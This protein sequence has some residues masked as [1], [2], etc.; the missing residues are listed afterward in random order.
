MDRTR[1]ADVANADL[2][3]AVWRKSRRSNNGGEC[4]EVADL[5]TS[6]GVRDSKN[7]DAGHLTFAPDTWAAFTVAVKRGRHDR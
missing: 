7:P 5:T 6:I 2:S 3:R 4:V 1:H